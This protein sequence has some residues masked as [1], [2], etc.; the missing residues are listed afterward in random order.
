MT[1]PKPPK[2]EITP[3]RSHDDPVALHEG[4]TPGLCGRI[5]EMHA[6]YYSQL[7]GFGLPFE[8]LVAGGMAEFL[9]RLGS[10]QN[11]TWCVEQAGQILGG[12]SIDGEDLGGNVAHLRWFIIDDTLR[13]RG[14]GQQLMLA[15]MQFC[16]ERGFDEV[17]LWT[18][19]GLD[20]ARAL[21]ER[22][23]FV[24]VDEWQGDQ[25]GKAVK[26]QKF[27]CRLTG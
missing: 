16:R 19:R 23:G 10:P 8:T 14:M 6:R 24:L 2:N 25:Y 27:V 13:G 17:H 21:Y 22:H 7:T 18:F 26:E 11:S 15:A 1:K 20:A 3:D 12:V 4:Y 9:S 5:T